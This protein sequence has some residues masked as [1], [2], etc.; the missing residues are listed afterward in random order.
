MTKILK[1]DRAA[2]SPHPAEEG[3]SLISNEKLLAIYGAMVKC[4]MLEQRAATLFQAGKLKSDLSSSLKREG[5][6]AAVSV[7]LLAEDLLCIAPGDWF[8]AFVKGMPL[9]GVF[10]ALSNQPNA[11]LTASLLERNVSA[12]TDNALQ[13]EMVR[14]RASQAL[15]EKKNAIVVVFVA[16]GADALEPW[17]ETMKVAA[18]KKL[19]ILF[20]QHVD[21]ELDSTKAGNKYPDA[22]VHGVAAIDVDALDAVAVYRVAY[23]GVVRA[24]QARGAS[25]LRCAVHLNVPGKKTL[26]GQ[27]EGGGATISDPLIAME[28]YLRS[29]AID[30]EVGNRQIVESFSR[31]LDVATRFLDR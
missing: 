19:P 30:S 27:G 28:S 24:R 5:T 15:A 21:E 29:K 26:D 17:R 22:L 12:T 11:D 13:T 20:V 6:A 25:L 9:E 8:P 3:F 18:A 16:R 2:K 14:K 4:R 7:N 23:E 1:K 10:R 31:D